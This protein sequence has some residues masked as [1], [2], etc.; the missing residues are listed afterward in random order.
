M[1]GNDDDISALESALKEALRIARSV[2]SAELTQSSWLEDSARLGTHLN[3]VRRSMG[4]IRCSV[5]ISSARDAILLYLR[6]NV[7]VAV[8]ADALSG[9]AGINAWARRVRELRVEEGWP[10]E[11]G[12]HTVDL[13][14]HHY[15]L[16]A[17]KP[18]LALAD[19]WKVAKTIRGMTHL[20]GKN[21][22]LEYLKNLS[23][24][25]ATQDQ[26]E[27][28]ARIRAW[29]RRM[30]ELDEEGWDIRSNVDEAHLPPGSYRLASLE[31]RPA[32]ARQA[33]KL[34]YEIMERDGNRCSDCGS[35]P[36][37][38]HI[39]LQVHHKLPVH[40]GGDNSTTNLMT[41]CESCHAGRHAVTNVSVRDELLHPQHEPPVL[42]EN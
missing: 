19:A 35:S 9:V 31:R 2:R 24:K 37:L 39:R 34:R 17:D 22:A 41:L 26:I 1:L 10:I 12:V 14:Y 15:R 3:N 36:D 16:T 25:A 11:S 4:D 20:S 32:R 7:G 42:D 8:S 21:R 33:T 29:Q 5:G 28:V 30:R 18:D 6:H 40:Q 23:P 27:Y 13:D 38:D